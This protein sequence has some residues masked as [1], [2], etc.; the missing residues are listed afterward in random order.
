MNALVNTWYNSLPAYGNSG[1][2]FPFYAKWLGNDG[3]GNQK[4][5]KC[6]IEDNNS[7]KKKLYNT[8]VRVLPS[9]WLVSKWTNTTGHRL[10]LTPATDVLLQ[11]TERQQVD[12]D[13][14]VLM[15]KPPQSGSFAMI[16]KGMEQEL[17]LV[18]N[19]TS[20]R[21]PESS[22]NTED[23]GQQGLQ[24]ILPDNVKE[25]FNKYKTQLA[26]AAMLLLII[27]IIRL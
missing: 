23:F 25:L 7:C 27:L 18:Q 5:Y 10:F 9:G 22:F 6:A 16:P 26:V 1:M 2:G 15:I 12:P 8:N 24:N 21:F 14:T 4:W 3:R 11:V 19:T 17:I 20:Q 13:E